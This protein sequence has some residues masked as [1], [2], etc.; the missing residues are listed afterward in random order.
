MSH[1][2]FISLRQELKD[3]EAEYSKMLE[4]LRLSHQEEVAS[5]LEQ[6][7]R[8]KEEQ[9]E[10]LRS[11]HSSEMVDLQQANQLAV[12]SLRETLELQQESAL[13][14]AAERHREEMAAMHGELASQHQ[15]EMSG[16]R[17]EYRNEV[18]RHRQQL[19]ERLELRKKEVR[20]F[21][22]PYSRKIWRGIKFSSLAVYLCNRQ[23]KIC[24][25]FLLAYS[26]GYILSMSIP[27]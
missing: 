24:Q 14:E 19:Q 8:E 18:E 2:H 26:A 25:F 16:L 27:C 5:Q 17:D 6:H 12:A 20:N 4:D 21:N 3:R 11:Q 7:K 10:K 22:L 13:R 9:S 15:A 23:I 1:F